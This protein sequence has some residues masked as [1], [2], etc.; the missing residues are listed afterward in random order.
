MLFSCHVRISEWI[1]TLYLPECQGTPCSKQAR[2]LKFNASNVPRNAS[3]LSLYRRLQKKHAQKVHYVIIMISFYVVSQLTF[4]LLVSEVWVWPY[5]RFLHEWQIFISIF[6]INFFKALWPLFMDEFYCLKATEAL[7]GGSLLFTTKF[8]E[9]PGTNLIGL[10]RP[11]GWVDLG[12]AQWFVSN[13][14]LL[15]LW[16][17]TLS[18]MF[19][20]LFYKTL[21][22]KLG[23]G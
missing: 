17:F 15:V 10:G 12:A 11:K 21:G 18:Q 4:N 23:Q 22:S 5:D 3:Y 19:H 6:K 13:H 20:I 14:P 9:I 1:D 8:P 16:S 7:R 2:Y